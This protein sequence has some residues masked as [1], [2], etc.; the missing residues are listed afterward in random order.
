[1]IGIAIAVAF[2]LT[3]GLAWWLTPPLRLKAGIDPKRWVQVIS[4]P[5][6]DPAPPPPAPSPAAQPTPAMPRT[7]PA[8]S[9]PRRL[10]PSPDGRP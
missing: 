4:V 9:A 8:A 5:R 1:M 7:S 2:H 10:A 3:L 6:H